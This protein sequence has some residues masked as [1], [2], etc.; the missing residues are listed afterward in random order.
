MPPTYL[1]ARA[2][3]PTAFAFA[4][5]TTFLSAQPDAGSA[6]SHKLD[7]GRPAS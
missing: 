5:A 4:L 7:S 1:S 6:R 3:R 2:L